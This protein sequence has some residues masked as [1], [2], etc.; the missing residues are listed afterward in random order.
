MLA[1]RE[2]LILATASPWKKG[3]WKMVTGKVSSL[4]EENSFV[5]P[6]LP[7]FQHKP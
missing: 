5:H 2:Q 1:I 3:S 7:G 4:R 6:H